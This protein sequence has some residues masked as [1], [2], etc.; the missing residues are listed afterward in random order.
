MSAPGRVGS[1]EAM[2]SPQEQALREERSATF[3]RVAGVYDR[4]RPAYPDRATRFLGGEAPARVLD[5]GAG[6]GK[7]TR[8]LAAAGH[9]VTAADPSV[10]MLEQLASV[11]DISCVAAQAEH[12][13]FPGGSFDV[14]VVAQ[15]F[16]WFDPAAALPQ[17]ARV[18]DDGGTLALVWNQRD[19]SIPWSRRLT[20]VVGSDSHDLAAYASRLPASGLFCDVERATY[21]FWQHLDLA[22]LLGLVGSRSYVIALD[23][24]ERDA[25]LERVRTLYAE[26][27]NGLGGLRLRYATHCFRATVDKTALP[28]DTEPPGG[29]DLLFAFE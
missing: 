11:S 17:I 5:L 9:D 29:G 22:G 23:D 8:A 14:V 13:P 6:T 4:T 2:E 28:G 15:A 24:G 10:P 20:E 12:L 27:A 25:L 3:G 21:G 18:L 19:E 1:L 16:H 7:L 26:H